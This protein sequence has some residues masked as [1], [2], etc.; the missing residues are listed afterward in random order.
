MSMENRKYI[1]AY[2]GGGSGRDL[3]ISGFLLSSIRNH[4]AITVLL[5]L[6]F[7]YTEAYLTPLIT[8]T[9]RIHGSSTGGDLEFEF[10]KGAVNVIQPNGLRCKDKDVFK[11]AIETLKN[12]MLNADE[13]II[14][15]LPETHLLPVDFISRL[16]E[17]EFDAIEQLVVSCHARNDVDLIKTAVNLGAKLIRTP[18]CWESSAYG[19]EWGESLAILPAYSS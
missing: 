12:K 17:N 5:D 13:N 18:F 19:D 15:F 11:A 1:L 8:H 7:V 6:H 2:G 4:D 14:L 3:V 16:M 10:V 9:H